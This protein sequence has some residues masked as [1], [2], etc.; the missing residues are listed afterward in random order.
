MILRDLWTILGRR[1]TLVLL[2]T[3]VIVAIGAWAAFSQDRTYRSSAGLSLLPSKNPTAGYSRNAE[4][5]LNTYAD[6]LRDD[7]FS[8]TVASSVSF[9]ISPDE[10]EED[11]SLEPSESS[12]TI[13]VAGRR[14]GA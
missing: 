9:P 5:F 13:V 2:V 1:R 4:L 12:A 6:G 10:V 11:V 14:V 8:D 3:A 7:R